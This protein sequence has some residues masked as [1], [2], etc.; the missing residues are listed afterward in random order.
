MKPREKELIELVDKSEI[1]TP[2]ILTKKH[3]FLYDVKSANDYQFNSFG[4]ANEAMFKAWSEIKIPKFAEDD[5]EEDIQKTLKSLLK[6]RCEDFVNDVL[7]ESMQKLHKIAVNPLSK[8]RQGNWGTRNEENTNRNFDTSRF[9]KAWYV[10]AISIFLDTVNEENINETFGEFIQENEENI[11]D[12]I[13]KVDKNLQLTLNKVFRKNYYHL[14]DKITEAKVVFFL[15]HHSSSEEELS[16]ISSFTREQYLEVIV[17]DYNIDAEYMTRSENFLKQVVKNIEIYKNFTTLIKNNYRT[18]EIIKQKQDLISSLAKEQYLTK[19]TDKR[20]YSKTVSEAKH[21][22]DMMSWR[23]PQISLKIQ[24]ELMEHL[25][26]T[27]EFFE[28]KYLLGFIIFTLKND[29]M[30]EKYETDF[31]MDSFYIKMIEILRKIK[32]GKTPSEKVYISQISSIMEILSEH[33]GTLW[34]DRR[35]EIT[36]VENLE[37]VIFEYISEEDNSLLPFELFT[38]ILSIYPILSDKIVDGSRYLKSSVIRLLRYEINST[39]GTFHDPA[40]DSVRE[41]L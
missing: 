18:S 9:S 20:E 35:R 7:N 2:K 15:P 22:T 24:Y 38:S 31:A 23:Y 25:K 13:S 27:K 39:D 29:K 30:F 8:K 11:Y 21:F 4:A 32:D 3:Q 6:I 14:L 16:I 26:E 17:F 19:N 40:H 1:I 33:V 10:A 34:D 5:T 36:N 12:K 41:P 37:K 28:S